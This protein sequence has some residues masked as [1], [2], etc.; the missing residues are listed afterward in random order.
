MDGY[1]PLSPL[2]AILGNM[3]FLALVV[4]RFL[5]FL[6]WL[7]NHLWMAKT[8]AE[9]A[10]LRRVGK[11]IADLERAGRESDLL[12]LPPDPAAPSSPQ[13]IE[14]NPNANVEDA[15]E[16]MFEVK[17]RRKADGAKVYKEF[18]LHLLGVTI[19]VI[20]CML[21][22]FSAWPLLSWEPG[23]GLTALGGVTAPWEYIL[24]GIIIGSGSKPIHFLIEFLIRRKILLTREEQ[25]DSPP[26]EVE[27]QELPP[28]AEPV[29]SAVAATTGLTAASIEQIVGF[30]Y[31]GGDRSGRLENTHLRKQA[32]DLIVYHHTTM[33]S[34][35]PFEEVVRE[36]D[37]KGWLTGYHAVVFKDGALRFICRWDRVGN[38]A[39]GFN[40]RSLGIAFQGNFE[41]DPGVPGSNPDGRKGLK[42]PAPAQLDAASRLI[43]FWSLFYK[44]RFQFPFGAD[45]A[46]AGSGETPPGIVPH[47][48]LA[49]TACPGSG[50]PHL[51]FQ[52]RIQHYHDLWKDDAGFK[53]AMRLFETTPMVRLHLQPTV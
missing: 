18:Y 49:A 29:P 2:L 24:T 8:S 47:R 11:R 51:L 13:E 16:G 27:P 50:F 14:V 35:A 40:F 1:V 28:Q 5:Q 43:A 3:L 36:F 34:E 22:G 32:I 9:A 42:R 52:Q 46:R 21:S 44:V 6:G 20:L 17:L 12:S 7:M 38:H 53:T 4:E 45:R 15:A 33:H 23:A 25:R 39:K 37:R 48:Y 31:Q 30:G 10:P 19:A 41:I 26:V